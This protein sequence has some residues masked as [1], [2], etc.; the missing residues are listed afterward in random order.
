[1]EKRKDY[2]IDFSLLDWQSPMAGVRQK[3]V[4][5]RGR[6]LRLVEYTPEMPPHW[7]TKGHL[8]C[9]LEG[10]F[11]IEFPDGVRIFEQGDGVFIPDGEEHK[12]K[13]R[14][15]TDVVRAVFVEDS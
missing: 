5:G 6:K 12:H 10:R 13:A 9:I 3:A 15:L 1:M 11:E 8:G 7:C 14:A 4:I 2:R